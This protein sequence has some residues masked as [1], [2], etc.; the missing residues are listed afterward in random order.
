M[1][2]IIALLIILIFGCNEKNSKI[3]EIVFADFQDTSANVISNDSLFIASQTQKVRN[4]NPIL[5]AEDNYNNDN[6][7]FIGYFGF[8]K[9]FPAL[10]DSIINNNNFEKKL[11]L[12]TSDSMDR[13]IADLVTV[14][15]EFSKRYNER[16]I[17]LLYE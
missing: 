10:P 15:K 2:P 14:S 7:Y 4:T 11:I 1:K 13:Y 6:I 17:Q 12:G 8:S 3:T 5:L 9:T 16:M